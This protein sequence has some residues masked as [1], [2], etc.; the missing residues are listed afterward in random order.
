MLLVMLLRPH[1]KKNYIFFFFSRFP[2]V[3]CARV[4]VTSFLE[5]RKYNVVVY[6][7]DGQG[8]TYVPVLFRPTG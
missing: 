1:L 4:G 5:F 7:T 3:E 2:F 8:S 6:P